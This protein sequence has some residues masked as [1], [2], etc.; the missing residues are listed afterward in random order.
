[1]E[2]PN[3]MTAQMATKVL[4]AL[5]NLLVDHLTIAIDRAEDIVKTHPKM[6]PDLKS[7]LQNYASGQ[8]GLKTLFSRIVADLRSQI[9][10]GGIDPKKVEEFRKLSDSICNSTS[11]MFLRF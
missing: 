5:S 4:D 11:S 3:Y 9:Q 7:A 1:M 8:R 10:K 6:E 2:K